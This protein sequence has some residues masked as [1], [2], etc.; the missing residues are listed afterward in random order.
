ME[1]IGL[2]HAEAAAPT[3]SSD[4]PWVSQTERGLHVA[5]PGIQLMVMADDEN[6]APLVLWTR[7]LRG[8]VKLVSQCSVT[9]H[10]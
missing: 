4:S 7:V 2:G 3:G 9:G 6:G 10:P 1:A 5:V 8:M